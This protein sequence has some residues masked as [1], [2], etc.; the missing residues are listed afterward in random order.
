MSGAK[1]THCCALIIV[2]FFTFFAAFAAEEGARRAQDPYVGAIAVDADT[3]R[4]LFADRAQTRGYP[5][6]VTKVM[7]AY[8]VL[9]DVKAGKLTLDTPIT[10]SPTRTREEV[11][12][13]KPS[14]IGMMTGEQL[15]VRELLVFL[16]VKSANDGAIFLAEA[17][18]GDVPRFVSRMNEKAQ[19][20]GML[21]TI[22]FN[23][24]G[25]PPW[26]RADKRY[27]ISTC[28]DLAKLARAL[29]AEHPEVL[30]YTS[31]KKARVRVPETRQRDGKRQ[32]VAA[33]IVNHNNVM[34]KNALKII[35]PDGSEAVDGLK[36][37]YIDLGGSSII[38][39]GKRKGH[40]AIVVVL[41]AANAKTRDETARRL[42]VS[43]LDALAW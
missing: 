5:A 36:T 38:L 37:G 19:A 6:S 17:C 15:S 9:D 4:V 10:A 13:R 1:R 32:W 28:E 14:C 21:N 2:A 40:R 7:T 24:N 23:P 8:L 43:A 41:G 31:I 26:P 42:L 29:L 35:N 20:L 25:M 39:T 27:N 22:Y 30:D 18:A 34:V 33:E 3:G 12:W 16:M 11:E